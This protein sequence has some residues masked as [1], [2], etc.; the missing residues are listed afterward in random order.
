MS[1][2]KVERFYDSIKKYRTVK[3]VTRRTD[4]EIEY[5]NNSCGTT[6]SLKAYYT[7]Y[8][9]YLKNKISPNQNISTQSLLG[10]LLSKF[11]LNKTQQ[12]EFRYNQAIE[13][14]NAQKNLR[15]LYNIEQYINTAQRLMNAVSV[16]D[17]ILSLCALTGRRSA[18]IACTAQ[19]SPLEDDKAALFTGQLKTKDR[20]GI[21]PYEIPLLYEYNSIVKVLSSIREQK[22]Q[23]I[24]QPSLFN[25]TA[26][27]NIGARAKKHFVDTVEGNI[28]VKDLRSIYTHISYHNYCNSSPNDFV[29]ISQNAYFAKILGHSEEDVVTCGSYIDFCLPYKK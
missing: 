28:Q 17:R 16:Y 7:K 27:K 4:L 1:I 26:S 24:N 29:N 6:A 19:F 21:Q 15:K 20:D 5:L 22:P 18:E 3:E 23:F 9:N 11:K 12:I 8:R 14:S 25:S 10:F 13:V 2:C